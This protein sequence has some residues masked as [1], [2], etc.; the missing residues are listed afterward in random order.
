MKRLYIKP[1]QTILVSATISLLFLC[2]SIIAA[3]ANE[4]PEPEDVIKTWNDALYDGNIPLARKYTSITASDYIKNTWGSLE[5]LS[6]ILQQ[7]INNRASII[8]NKQDINGRVSVVEYTAF[9][10]DNSVK[11][12]MDTLFLESGV[13]KVAPQFAKTFK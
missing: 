6:K 7:S 12:W 3:E 5:G 11:E 8:V 9:Y 2:S 13:W 10:P 1:H 4:K